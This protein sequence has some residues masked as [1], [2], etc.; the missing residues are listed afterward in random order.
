MQDKDQ[1]NDLII[2]Q[3]IDKTL[4]SQWQAHWRG[5]GKEQAAWP[6]CRGASWLHKSLTWT[7]QTSV[8]I[9]HHH[10]QLLRRSSG[11]QEASEARVCRWNTIHYWLTAKLREEVH[12]RRCILCNYSSNYRRLSPDTTSKNI[13]HERVDTWSKVIKRHGQ[14]GRVSQRGRNHQLGEWTSRS[15]YK[16]KP[17]IFSR[18]L[19]PRGEREGSF[20]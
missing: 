19:E 8:D 12:E 18:Q 20:Q 1:D 13:S 15:C 6:V 4:P 7:W 10:Q 17:L 16:Q 5:S 3:A 14:L 9:E 2:E 11:T